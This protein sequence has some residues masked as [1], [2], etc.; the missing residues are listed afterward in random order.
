MKASTNKS[1]FTCPYGKYLAVACFLLLLTSCAGSRQ[2]FVAA[3]R[4]L[5]GA[6]LAE[7]DG[8]GRSQLPLYQPKIKRG[9]QV[10]VD[11]QHPLLTYRYT[12]EVD[13]E[14][15]LILPGF[16]TMQVLGM[17][18]SELEALLALKSQ[19]VILP[20]DWIK[21]RQ[22][23]SGSSMP[24]SAQTSATSSSEA[25]TDQAA[26]TP[27][28][29]IPKLSIVNY[30]IN[31]LGLVERPGQYPVPA[32]QINVFEA[33]SLAGYKTTN[34]KHGSIKVL[35][36]A[37]DGSLRFFTLQL[38]DKQIIHSPAYYLE[39]NDVLYVHPSRKGKWSAGLS[40]P[41]ALGLTSLVS[42]LIS[43]ATLVVH[44]VK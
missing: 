5:S 36:E 34:S 16:A 20:A 27:A 40:S 39:Q 10:Q 42:I 21:I 32:Q 7:L 41:I 17:S 12:A 2:S 23:S 35:R 18:L 14:G 3:D 44:I 22:A 29:W 25:L 6:E 4:S 43:A 24:L 11:L 8:S 13:K 33:L 37:N 9:D 38:D 1:S 15:H 31:V 26:A 30:R 28:P 19:A